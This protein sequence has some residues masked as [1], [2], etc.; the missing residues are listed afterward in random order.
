MTDTQ[1]KNANTKGTTKL[2]HSKH[3]SDD[4]SETNE[5]ETRKIEVHIEQTETICATQ[6]KAKFLTLNFGSVSCA[7]TRKSLENLGSMPALRIR[8]A[9]M[10]RRFPRL[11]ASTDGFISR[12]SSSSDGWQSRRGHR[13]NGGKHK[14][15]VTGKIGQARSPGLSGPVS[16]VQLRLSLACLECY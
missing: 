4:P 6:Q 15:Q 11:A 12:P 3:S 5:G 16:A 14:K 13:A 1:L 8:D 9:L 2:R 10:M 7:M